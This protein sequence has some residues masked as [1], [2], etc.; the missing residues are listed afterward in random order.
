MSWTFGG[1]NDNG[2]LLDENS[3]KNILKCGTEKTREILGIDDEEDTIEDYLSYNDL[4]DL[5]YDFTGIDC[6]YITVGTFTKLV[7]VNK[8]GYA[9]FDSGVYDNFE[10]SMIFLF[11]L[12]KDKL[13]DKYNSYGEIVQE[14]EK[15]IVDEMGIDIDKLYEKF[16]TDYIKD[17]IGNFNGFYSDRQEIF[18]L[19]YMM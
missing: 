11:Y 7:G 1:Y 16:G 10:D 18:D 15:F 3:F 8:N 2:L 19:W 6:S 17:R 14:V 9:V 4:A 5:A 13:F 12:K